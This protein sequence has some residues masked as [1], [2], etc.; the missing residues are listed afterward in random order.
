MD[1]PYEISEALIDK[2]GFEKILRILSVRSSCSWVDSKCSLPVH[3]D[4]AFILASTSKLYGSPPYS[5]FGMRIIK[6]LL[7]LLVRGR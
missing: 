4:V 5:K 3:D 7:W 6:W 1:N 2:Y